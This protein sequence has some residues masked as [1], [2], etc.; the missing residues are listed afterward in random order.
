LKS[1]ILPKRNKKD[2]VEVPKQV[3]SELD[4]IDVE[5]MDQV[6]DIALLPNRSNRQSRKSKS[7]KPPTDQPVK[8]GGDK[9]PVQPRA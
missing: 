5:H 8:T 7:G 2:L 3:Q 9:P 4:L 6:L 1:I